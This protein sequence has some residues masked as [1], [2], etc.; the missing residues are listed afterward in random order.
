VTLPQIFHGSADRGG[1]RWVGGQ[2]SS[3]IW[4]GGWPLRW[5]AMVDRVLAG[6][7]F[8]VCSVDS[9]CRRV[10]PR[11]PM[12]AGQRQHAFTSELVVWGFSAP[13]LLFSCIAARILPG[14]AALTDVSR[15]ICLFSRDH[16]RACSRSA[17]PANL[18]Q[19]GRSS[20]A[21]GSS[22]PP[23]SPPHPAAIIAFAAPCPMQQR[24]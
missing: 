12:L 14:P 1:P 20:L 22:G 24:T 6:G 7:R 16:G 18:G 10:R 21:Y 15:V 3:F 5:L 11:L 13:F 8:N 23:C 9:A 4:G 2:N 17:L 19:S